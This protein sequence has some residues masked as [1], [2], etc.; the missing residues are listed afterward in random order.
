MSSQQQDINEYIKDRRN[1]S[2]FHEALRTKEYQ[3]YPEYYKIVR[4]LY[5]IFEC[6][7]KLYIHPRYD[8]ICR[9]IENYIDSFVEDYK[10]MI[11]SLSSSKG[12][13]IIIYKYIETFEI[14]ALSIYYNDFTDDELYKI[15]QVL[16]NKNNNL[17]RLKLCEFIDDYICHYEYI[18]NK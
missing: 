15:S 1:D 10:K 14:N 17:D 13:G 4:K 16:G 11:E 3:Y 8:T 7:D 18:C 9:E 5:D 6:G 12:K 2:Q